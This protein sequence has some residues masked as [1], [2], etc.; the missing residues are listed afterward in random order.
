[1]SYEGYYQYICPNGHYW[2]EDV[3]GP[4][5]KRCLTCGELRVWSNSVDTTNGSWEE[6]GPFDDEHR[7]DG[8]VVLELIG[9]SKC[10]CCG[11]VKEQIYKIP[12]EKR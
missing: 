1:M 8:H 4:N 11:H 7:I 10:E 2:A 3:Y 9:E 12:G 5:F 6:D